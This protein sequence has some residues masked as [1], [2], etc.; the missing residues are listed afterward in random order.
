MK[1][2]DSGIITYWDTTSESQYTKG[3]RRCMNSTIQAVL[4][5]HR[6]SRRES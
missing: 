4:M 5:N 3:E 2:C 1:N 6:P